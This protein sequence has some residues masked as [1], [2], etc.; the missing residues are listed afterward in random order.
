[1]GAS[2]SAG[3]AQRVRA[4]DRFV[5]DAYGGQEIVEAGVLP[6]RVLESCDHFERRLVGLPAPPVRVAI[7]GLDLVRDRDGRFHVLED[8]VRT[9]SGTTYTLAARETLDRHLPVGLA[10]RR[11]PLDDLLDTLAE[12]RCGQPR[13]RESTTRQSWCSRMARRTARGT[14]TSASPEPSRSRS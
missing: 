9:P 11:R 7:A 8:N 4:L 14:S 5:A 12:T 6:A 1:M 2:S 10:E 3:L 13:P